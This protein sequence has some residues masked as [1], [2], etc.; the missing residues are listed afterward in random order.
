MWKVYND[1]SQTTTEKELIR[2]TWAFGPYE[3]TTT[4][5]KIVFCH[6]INLYFNP[7]SKFKIVN[8]I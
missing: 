7:P 5:M 6:I 2:D 4:I 3:L 8:M 1:D